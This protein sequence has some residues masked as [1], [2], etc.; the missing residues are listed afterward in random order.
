LTFASETRTCL[1]F[2]QVDGVGGLQS[3]LTVAIESSKMCCLSL[4]YPSATLIFP[5]VHEI[6]AGSLS[7]DYR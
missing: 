3:A 2:L 4:K 5:I 6:F 1:N 7:W